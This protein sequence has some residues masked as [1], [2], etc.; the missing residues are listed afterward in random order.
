MDCFFWS[1][2]K[3][4]SVK[5]CIPIAASNCITYSITPYSFVEL[6]LHTLCK[7]FFVNRSQLQATDSVQTL[8]LHTFKPPIHIYRNKG[9]IGCS[10][11]CM[12]ACGQLL[13]YLH[14][15]LAGLTQHRHPAKLHVSQN[16]LIRYVYSITHTHTHTYTCSASLYTNF[17]H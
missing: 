14:T 5:P 4:I 1:R 9:L 16:C 13:D 11:S 12:H 8:P 10:R 15:Y 7:E 6:I 3:H 17:R 2:I